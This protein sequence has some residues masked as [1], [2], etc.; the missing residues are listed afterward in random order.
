MYVLGVLTVEIENIIDLLTRDIGS[1]FSQSDLVRRCIGE[2]EANWSSPGRLVFNHSQGS[3]V[4]ILVFDFHRTHSL[5]VVSSKLEVKKKAQAVPTLDPA[6]ATA[7]NSLFPLRVTAVPKVPLDFVFSSSTS[8]SAG[9]VVAQAVALP[10]I[11]CQYCFSQCQPSRNASKELIAWNSLAYWL[12]QSL[13]WLPQQLQPCWHSHYVESEGH[14][15]DESDG[16]RH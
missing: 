1:S 9:V 13:S 4:Y 14:P 3:F 6:N 8:P 2:S 16:V 10:V 15:H 7:C 12:K 5:V 11:I